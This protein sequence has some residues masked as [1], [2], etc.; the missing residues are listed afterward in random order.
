[1]F[2]DYENVLLETAEKNMPHILCKYIYDLTKSFSTFYN[3]VR[4][5]DEENEEKKVLKLMLVDYY[6]KFL[7][8][9]FSLLA[10]E[11]PERM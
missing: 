10:I 3:N 6:A 8:D 11:M 2:L 5:L 9:S 4:V 7:K 1:L